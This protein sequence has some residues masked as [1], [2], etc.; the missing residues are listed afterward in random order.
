MI[1]KDEEGV[2]DQGN[3]FFKGLNDGFGKFQNDLEIVEAC[4]KFLN[5]GNSSSRTQ[6]F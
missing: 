2:K 3:P 4:E 5:F 6:N 1:L